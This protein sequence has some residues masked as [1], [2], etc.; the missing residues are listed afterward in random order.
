MDSLVLPRS[1]TPFGNA[2][3]PDNSV[4]GDIE[5]KIRNPRLNYLK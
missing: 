3:V 1:Q 2:P 5:N 4:V